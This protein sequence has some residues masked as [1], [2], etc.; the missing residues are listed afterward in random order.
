VHETVCLKI[1]DQIIQLYSLE[2]YTSQ[3]LGVILVLCVKEHTLKNQ[4]LTHSHMLLMSETIA[5]SACT[6]KH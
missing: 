5:S 1:Y 3:L 4:D 6:L 2:K